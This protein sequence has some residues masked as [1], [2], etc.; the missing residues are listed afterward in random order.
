VKLLISL[1]ALFLSIALVQMGIGT[2]RPFDAISGHALGFSSIQIG[3][4]ASGHFSGFLLGCVFSPALV[5]RV[6]HSRAF[7]VMAGIAVISIIAHPLYPNAYFWAF[8]RIFAGFSVAGCYTLI[9]SWLQAK[10]TNQIRGRVF[11]VYRLVDLSG[12]LLANAAIATLTAGSYFSYN[13]IAIVMCLSILPLALTQSKE[14]A[15]PESIS[16][17]PLFAFGV[18][19][20]AAFGVAIAG[21]ST[22]TF[23]SVAPIFASAVGLSMSQIA[24]FLV[25]SI[26]GGLLSQL[27]SGM[28]ADRFPRRAVLMGFSVL[29]TLVSLLFTTDLAEISMYGVPVVF[30]LSF[31]F[32]FTTF[33]IYSICASHACDFVEETDLLVLSASL[34]FI[35]AMGAIISPLIAGW[36]IDLF[37]AY[38][39]FSFIS[40]AHL[41][42]MLYT[43]YRNAVGPASRFA[44]DY[45]YV[46]RTSMFIAKILKGRR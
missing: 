29:A 41:V 28:L 34:I 1:S 15:L 11:G 25:A 45:A 36:L 4:I 2:L 44:R 40:G 33:P 42:L 12:Q 8:I 23:G 10:V 6:G 46:P 16:Y 37:G 38:A 7:A 24:L 32:G 5:K 13:L 35:Y 21:L 30:G 26:I 22:A 19:P 31:L 27:P 20:L 39:M 9:E 14:P 3:I 18:S 43:I 17:K